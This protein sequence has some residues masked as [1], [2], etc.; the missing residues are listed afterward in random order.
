MFQN[1]QSAWHQVFTP[2]GTKNIETVETDLEK[3]IEMRSYDF[4]LSLNV[5]SY[6]DAMKDWPRNKSNFG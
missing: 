4:S 1:T 5:T 6:S 2:G 3:L